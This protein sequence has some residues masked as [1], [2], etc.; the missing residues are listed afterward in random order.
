M[1]LLYIYNLKIQLT[2]FLIMNLLY[3]YNLKNKVNNSINFYIH[4]FN[5]NLYTYS[6]LYKLLIAKI[7]FELMNL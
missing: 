7:N 2:Y 1:N 3:I 5:V 6:N 4:R